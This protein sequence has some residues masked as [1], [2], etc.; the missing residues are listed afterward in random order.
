MHSV[1]KGISRFLFLPRGRCAPHTGVMDLPSTPSDSRGIF[2]ENSWS[3]GSKIKTVCTSLG[4]SRETSQRG[5]MEG[6]SGLTDNGWMPSAQEIWH[7]PLP[8]MRWHPII[9]LFCRLCLMRFKSQVI[10][11]RGLENVRVERDPFIVALN[12]SQRYE[13]LIVPAL[14]AF[15]RGGKQVHFLADWNFLIMPGIGFLIHCNNP[16]VT[17]HKP[18]KPK[19][20]NVLKPFYTRRL[21]P[22]AQARERLLEGRSI[23]LFPEGTVNRDATKL[24]RGH[25]GAARLSLTTCTSVVPAGIRFPEQNP[26]EPISDQ[27]RMEIEFGS[28]I[29]PCANRP[30]LADREGIQE[31]HGRIMTEISR[32]SHKHWHPQTERR[33]LCLSTTESR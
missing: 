4:A 9:R 25:S 26:N 7:Q 10:R 17:T 3:A 16:I 18:A 19:V 27:A 29:E 1:S 11:V 14:L 23:G 8:H 28:P 20:L 32:L 12:H 24:L 13:A 15:Y 2:P 5:S 22:F 33:K 6:S 31:L 21:T 30:S